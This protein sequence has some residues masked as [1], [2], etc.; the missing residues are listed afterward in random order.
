MK[1]MSLVLSILMLTLFVSC[2]KEASK[3]GLSGAQEKALEIKCSR[4]LKQLGLGL[5]LYT[6]DHNDKLPTANGWEKEL[7]DY[8]GEEVV[9][10][11]KDK[12]QYRFFGNGQEL[13]EI[14]DLSITIV[15]ICEC[16]HQQGKRNALFVDGHFESVDP[17]QLEKAIEKAQQ[18]KTLPELQ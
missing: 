10:C 11:P 18:L 12:H 3:A 4:K 8:V 6:N 17:Q 7:K 14:E 13:C 16:D 9:C 5:M 15:A 1:K 2:S